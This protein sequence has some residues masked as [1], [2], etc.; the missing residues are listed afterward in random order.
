MGRVTSWSYSSW[1]QFTQCPAQW[2]YERI[3][4]LPKAPPGPP[5][6]RGIAIHEALEAYLK[7]P[8]GAEIPPD[9]E[10]WQHEL[11]RLRSLPGLVAEGQFAFTEAGEVCDWKDWDRCWL[12]AKLDAHYVLKDTL[13][14][15]DFKT[16]RVRDQD[17]VHQLELYAWVGFTAFPEIAKVRPELWYLDAG[18]LDDRHLFTRRKDFAHLDRV[19]RSRAA[20]VLEAEKYDPKPGRHCHWCPYAGG[21]P[22]PKG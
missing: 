21:N 3:D 19:W 22:C 13:H 6:L 11:E 10:S 9:L 18:D 8:E 5:L 2:R 4:R 17:G 12:R 1:R 16:G 7:T 20:E 15:V 14:L